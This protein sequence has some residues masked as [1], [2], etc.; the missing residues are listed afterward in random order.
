MRRLAAGVLVLALVIRVA[1]VIATPDYVMRA[2]S[3]DYERHALAI[4]HGHYPGPGAGLRGATA[5]RPPLYPI[6]LGAVYRLAAGHDRTWARMAQAVVGT[7]T[8]ALVGLI[9]WQ[10]FGGRASV[11]AMALG[12]VYPSMWMVGSALLSEVLL[13]PLVLAAVAAALRYRLREPRMRWAVLAGGLAGLAVLTRQNAALMLLP[14]GLALLPPRAARRTARAWA[15]VAALLIAATITVAP[16]TVRNAFAL[17]S[18]VP[19]STQDG[20][21]L[22]GT[23]NDVARKQ[24]RWPAAWVQWFV[25]PENLEILRRTPNTEVD[26]G[27]ALRAHALR[28]ARDHPGY[29]AKVAWWN[30][31]RDFDAAGRDWIRFDL[32]VT[33]TPKLVDVELVSFWAVALLAIGGAFTRAARR[34]P[35]WVWLVPASMAATVLIVGYLRFRAPIDPFLVLLAALGG[36]ALFDAVH[37]RL[38]PRGA[39]APCA[40]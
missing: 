1:V 25:V 39:T 16:W 33:A 7:L 18:F 3:V 34:A 26:R 9:A 27:D 13:A 4:E 24:D 31:R 5:Y 10:L 36:L 40:E 19:V 12:A 14:L 2:D 11:A 8:V 21:T 20:Y 32:G 37:A 28:Y 29:V 6:F 38:R 35:Y 23:Y 17:H 22:A 15:P 30:L